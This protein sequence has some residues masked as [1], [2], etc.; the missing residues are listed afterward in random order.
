MGKV[1]CKVG[2]RTLRVAPVM[3]PCKQV[4]TFAARYDEHLGRPFPFL[5]LRLTPAGSY[6]LTAV[7]AHGMFDNGKV[8]HTVVGRGREG[9]E[10]S[11][12]VTQ[13]A[14][15]GRRASGGVCGGL[16]LRGSA[17]VATLS[18]ATEIKHNVNRRTKLGAFNAH[19]STTV[20]RAT[21]P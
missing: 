10:G 8:S 13:K 11:G 16:G 6:A 19:L 5:R 20:K 2:G 3:E 7:W 18:G 17:G 4:P 21:L 9:S 12:G 15:E 1:L 14:G